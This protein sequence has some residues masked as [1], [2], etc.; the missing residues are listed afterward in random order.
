VTR[1]L[2]NCFAWLGFRDA[3]YFSFNVL[4]GILVFAAEILVQQLSSLLS[5]NIFLLSQK[6]L[7]KN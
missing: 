4:A 7:D 3:I 1:A 6:K 5:I 2:Q